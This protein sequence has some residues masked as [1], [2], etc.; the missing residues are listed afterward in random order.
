MAGQVA[1]CVTFL[2]MSV[3]H[4]SSG[5]DC[6]ILTGVSL[7]LTDPAEGALLADDDAE[8]MEDTCDVLDVDVST[9]CIMFC[10]DPV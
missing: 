10:R 6:L 3:V 2:S 5:R 7:P 1:Q 9:H 4:V 8:D